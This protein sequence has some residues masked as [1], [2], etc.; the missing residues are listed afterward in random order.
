MLKF[1]RFLHFFIK[2]LGKTYEPKTVNKLLSDM[3]NAKKRLIA[4]EDM[5]L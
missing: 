3:Q 1:R 5:K 4:I 2:S